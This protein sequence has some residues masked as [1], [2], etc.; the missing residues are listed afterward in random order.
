MQDEQGSCRCNQ[1]T[2]GDVCH[3]HAKMANGLIEPVTDESFTH[4]SKPIRV[5]R[6]DDREILW[7]R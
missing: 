7:E 1:S 6:I 3:Y 4:M 5:E 2:D